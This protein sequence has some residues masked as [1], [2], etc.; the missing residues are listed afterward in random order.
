MAVVMSQTN[1]KPPDE[2]ADVRE[3]MKTLKAREDELREMLISGQADLVGDDCVA[4]VSIVTQERVDTA[5]LR[6]ELGLE[7]LRPFLKMT[8]ATTVKVERMKANVE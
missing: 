2:L 6:A 3:Q 8:E 1:R 4:V 5:K 7:R